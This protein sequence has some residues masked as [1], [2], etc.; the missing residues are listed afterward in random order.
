MHFRGARPRAT[1]SRSRIVSCD[2]DMYGSCGFPTDTRTL[3]KR[4]AQTATAHARNSEGSVPGAIEETSWVTLSPVPR[5]MH[6]AV[7]GIWAGTLHPCGTHA[8]DAA[9]DLRCPSLFHHPPTR[10]CAVNLADDRSRRGSSRT[11]GAHV[12]SAT[13]QTPMRSTP[14]CRADSFWTASRRAR[15]IVIRTRA[16]RPSAQWASP[17][18]LADSDALLWW[19]PH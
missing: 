5:G 9:M 12:A 1:H 14:D 19:G 17:S 7:S 2:T 3:S 13:T 16:H 10:W 18:N 15:A 4:V 8:F 11:V 6:C